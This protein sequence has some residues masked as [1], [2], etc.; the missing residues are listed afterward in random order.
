MMYR[1]NMQPSKSKAKIRLLLPF[2]GWCVEA[3]GLHVHYPLLS[4]REALRKKTLYNS[5]TTKCFCP[6]CDNE[7][8]GSDS[9]GFLRKTEK[10]NFEVYKCSKCSEQ[11]FWDFDTYPVP[12]LVDKI[13]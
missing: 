3:R 6:Q 12:F 4:L 9:Y 2:Q 1:N 11:S 10:G 13:H 8:C 5:Q 7:L